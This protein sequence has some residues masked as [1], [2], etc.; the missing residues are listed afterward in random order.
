MPL[1]RPPDQ[2]IL[3]RFKNYIYYEDGVIT[4]NDSGPVSRFD[5]T[6]LKIIKIFEKKGIR[7]KVLSKKKRSH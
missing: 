1:F 3:G 2:K 7:Y 4:K 5:P 6:V